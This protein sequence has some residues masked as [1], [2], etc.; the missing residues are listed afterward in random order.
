VRGDGEAKEGICSGVSPGRAIGCCRRIFGKLLLSFAV[1]R[2]EDFG[3]RLA[4]SG[5]LATLSNQ[6]VMSSAV[7]WRKRH[8]LRKQSA[9]PP[10][11]RLP[12]LH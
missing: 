2:N 9:I 10:T 1:A 12:G 7:V 5:A 3:C 11:S 4:F 8:E 6:L